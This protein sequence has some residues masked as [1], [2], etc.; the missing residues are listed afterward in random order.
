[1]CLDALFLPSQIV[2][3]VSFSPMPALEAAQKLRQWRASIDHLD[4]AALR[5]SLGVFTV[6]WVL[7]GSRI[8]S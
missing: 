2:T 5:V 7:L 4:I 3:P 8:R 1:M 6:V